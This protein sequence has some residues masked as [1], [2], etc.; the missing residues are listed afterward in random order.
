MMIEDDSLQ[1][2]SSEVETDTTPTTDR[3]QNENISFSFA[4]I[5]KPEE[6][7][8]T[9]AWTLIND[10]STSNQPKVLLAAAGFRGVIRIIDITN[11]WNPNSLKNAGEVYHLVFSKTK[12]NLLVTASKNCTV[13]LWDV[14]ASINLVIFHG[15]NGHT[16]QVICADINDEGTMIASSGMDLTI[17]LWSLTKDEIV[18][19]IQIAEDNR[20]SSKKRLIKTSR[21]AFP[22][23]QATSAH[24]NFID[25]IKWYDDLIISRAAD[26][27]FCIWQCLNQPKPQVLFRWELSEPEPYWFIKFGISFA[28]QVR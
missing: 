6:M 25:C 27:T 13:C 24:E 21:I 7:F 5:I 2:T 20:N 8:Y 28:D 9:C 15:S 1:G 11:Q 23:A 14:L 19:Q 3:Q 18:K 26:D 10:S 16:D 17:N 4:H 22:D 12:P